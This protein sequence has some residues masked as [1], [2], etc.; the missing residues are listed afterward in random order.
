MSSSSHS[1]PTNDRVYLSFISLNPPTSSEAVK[2]SIDQA[3]RSLFGSV[4]HGRLA[5]SILDSQPVTVK[6]SNQM[7]GQRYILSIP[8]SIGFVPFRSALLLDDCTSKFEFCEFHE[9]SSLMALSS[10]Q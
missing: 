9:S 10:Q 8:S 6:Q 7:K 3:I 2:L 4:G 5:Y 1:L